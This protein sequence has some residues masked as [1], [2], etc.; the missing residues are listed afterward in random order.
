MIPVVY[1]VKQAVHGY[2][3]VYVNR[4]FSSVYRRSWLVRCAAGVRRVNVPGV[5]R[6]GRGC[7]CTQVSRDVSGAY[8]VFRVCLQFIIGMRRLIA[9]IRK[10]GCGTCVDMFRTSLFGT[11]SIPRC[12]LRC[13][14]APRDVLVSGC[15]QFSSRRSQ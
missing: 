8:R 3:R 4:V 2:S 5:Y 14:S 7:I 1:F 15:N 12:V 9:A 13:P 10:A 11:H 6:V